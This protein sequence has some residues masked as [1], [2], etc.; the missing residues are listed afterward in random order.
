MVDRF[1]A[2]YPGPGGSEQYLY[3]LDPPTEVALAATTSLASGHGVVVSAD[4]GPDLVLAWRR[5]SAVILYT[6]QALARLD[7][8]GLVAAQGPGDANVI[9]RHPTD[10]SV[11]P[12]PP[13]MATVQAVDVPLADPL[14][15]IWDLQSLG[16]ADRLEG[17]GRLRE[18][19]LTR[20]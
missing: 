18:W 2:D 3:S 17:A 14:Q 1:L 6:A 15:L 7:S 11:F 10:M 8:L 20:P 13:F 19:L 4:V 5:P 12:A 16:G 9:V